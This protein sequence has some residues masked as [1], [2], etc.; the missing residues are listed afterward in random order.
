MFGAAW[1]VL[2]VAT[3]EAISPL[4]RSFLLVS[5]GLGLAACG[6][7]NQQEPPDGGSN[8]SCGAGSN[9][10]ETCGDESCCSELQACADNA[11]CQADIDCV[12]GCGSDTACINTCAAD[13][14]AG[15]ADANALATCVNSYCSEACAAAPAD[16]SPVGTWNL[17]MS[18]AESSCGNPASF[19]TESLT[20]SQA[21]NGYNVVSGSASITGTTSCTASG[22]LV[23]LVL[24]FTVNSTAYQQTLNLSL[25]STGSLSGSG[26]ESWSTCSQQM[27]ITGS[28]L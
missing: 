26:I 10:C 15:V 4:T 9:A 8:H 3:M 12:A 14:S 22:C 13:H 2:F 23:S 28:R 21:A 24:D 11:S 6:G 1:H 19:N 17:D 7:M 18:F 5:L 25:G 16:F 27:S 20:I